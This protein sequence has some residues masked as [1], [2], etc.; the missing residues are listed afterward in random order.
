[1]RGAVHQPQPGRHPANAPLRLTVTLA[2]QL[3]RENVSRHIAV[4]VRCINFS[5]N[6]AA[7]KN[8][9]MHLSQP[10]AAE[11]MVASTRG[12]DTP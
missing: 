12:Y 8:L 1:V 5:K 6:K 7:A 11:K 2:G 4:D 3:S 10:A 9:L